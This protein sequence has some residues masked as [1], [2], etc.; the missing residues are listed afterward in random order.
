MTSMMINE[1]FCVC[2]GLIVADGLAFEGRMF[3][4]ESMTTA[5]AS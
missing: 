2:I 1:A 5:W 4:L 3:P